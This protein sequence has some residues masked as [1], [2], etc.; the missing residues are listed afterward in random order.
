MLLCS[1]HTSEQLQHVQPAAQRHNAT[2]ATSTCNPIQCS[3]DER[4]GSSDARTHRLELH[5]MFTTAAMH[6]CHSDKY[7]ALRML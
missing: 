4:T 1:L 3:P 2:D 7:A 5:P 6:A